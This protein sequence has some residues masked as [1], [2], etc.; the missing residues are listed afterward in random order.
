M[1]HRKAAI[2]SL[3]TTALI[4]FGI[5]FLHYNKVDFSRSFAR[6]SNTIHYFPNP[7]ITV[8]D[9]L[10]PF[11]KS[12]IRNVKRESEFLDNEDLID[13]VDIMQAGKFDSKRKFTHSTNT[14]LNPNISNH[15]GS[16]NSGGAIPQ[17]APIAGLSRSSTPSN[18]GVNG[19]MSSAFSNSLSVPQ[20][21]GDDK[22]F[23]DPSLDPKK[24]NQIPVGNGMWLLLFFGVL[25]GMIKKYWCKFFLNSFF[26]N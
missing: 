4:A 22:I 18:I 19:A 11:G 23:P 5:A 7:S 15:S 17:N 25:Y 21:Q 26:L 14:N 10:I 6:K 3:L 2:I 9:E 12:N 8:S 20:K 1:T 16:S 13:E 24:E